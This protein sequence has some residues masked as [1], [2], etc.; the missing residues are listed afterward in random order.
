[1][2]LSLRNTGS[3]PFYLDWPVAVALLDP[4]TKKPVWSAPL[5]GVDIRKWLPGEDW[6]STAFAYRRPAVPHHDEGFATVP[7]DMKPGEYIVALALLDRQGGMMP[8]A[9]FAIANYFR[10][11]WHPLGF[12]GVGEAPKEVAL[13]N[14][15]FDSPAFDDSLHYKVPEKL[16]VVKAPPVPQV[17]AVTS[18]TPDPDVELINPSR[19][20]IL[21]PPASS[22]EKQILTDGPGGSRVIRVTGEF[23]EGSSLYHNFGK[24]A[25]LDRGRYRFAF[26][27][28]GTLGQSVE[29]ELADGWRTVSKEAQIPLTDEWQEHAIEFEIKTTFKE[30]TILRFSLPRDVKGTF[31]LT[32]TRLKVV[33]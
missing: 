16:L 19:Y 1:M 18:W 31:D 25:K 6:D 32:N 4:A 2:K 11:G 27:V 26:R 8:S 33:R 23:G 30:E 14:M 15:K 21:H 28:R 12:I 22:L 9:R 29:F 10:G 5:S 17:K 7:A 13:K 24:A 20:W 3:A